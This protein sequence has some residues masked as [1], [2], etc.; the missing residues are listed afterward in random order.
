MHRWAVCAGRAQ[1]EQKGVLKLD[2][3]IVSQTGCG[4]LSD[5]LRSSGFPLSETLEEMLAESPVHHSERRGCGFTQTTRVLAQAAYSQESIRRLFL[6]S[7]PSA[8]DVRTLAR[9]LTGMGATWMTLLADVIA[10]EASDGEHVALLTGEH[11]VGTCSLAEKF[12][13][14][15]AHN[16]LPRRGWA[17]VFTTDGGEPALVEKV[18]MGE[19]LSALSLVPLEVNGIRF[20]EGSLFAVEH[21]LSTESRL[22]GEPRWRTEELGIVKVRFLRLTT[23]S[24]SVDER[25][26]WFHPQLTRQKRDSFVRPLKTTLAHLRTQAQKALENHV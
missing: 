24:A 6:D 4:Q 7:I 13:L 10:P 16:L 20:P 3:M 8:I 23:L 2:G 26:I 19:A 11:T 1:R 9:Q 5:A 21:N 14:E 18:H 12:F 17:R 22:R 15:L 25:M